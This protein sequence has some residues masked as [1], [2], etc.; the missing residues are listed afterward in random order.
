VIFTLLA[1]VGLRFGPALGLDA[2]RLRRWLSG[3]DSALPAFPWR[4]VAY[5]AL[6]AC[7]I[8][9]LLQA[10]FEPHLP[11]PRS[12]LPVAPTPLQGFFASFY[13]GIAE[14]LQLRLFLMTSVAAL[15]ARFSRLPLARAIVVAN[16]V[17]A[18]AFGA[19]HLPMASAIWPL[20][21]V[22]VAYIVAANAA[23]GVI[24]GALYARHGL[25]AAIAA[26]FLADIG[27]HV[28]VPLLNGGPA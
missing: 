2:P 22:V 23:A 3:A 28:V 21:A 12:A 1:V 7:A 25:E 24:F 6:L 13:G 20:D 26:H 19:G 8:V 17:A 27:L 9:V 16:V 10:G 14:E 4:A 5:S 15:L 18:L 11:R